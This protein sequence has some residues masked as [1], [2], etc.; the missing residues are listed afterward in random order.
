MMVLLFQ[1][2]T[3][4][5]DQVGNEKQYN[6]LGLLVQT[7]WD[8]FSSGIHAQKNYSFCIISFSLLQEVS[9]SKIEIIKP[10]KINII[11]AMTN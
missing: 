7:Y 2:F 9:L 6:K 5:S 8:I 10:Q 3:Q 1:W 4:S 11:E